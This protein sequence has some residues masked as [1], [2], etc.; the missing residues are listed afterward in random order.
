MP[1]RTGDDGRMATVVTQ[2]MLV[3][4]R[5]EGVDLTGLSAGEVARE[6]APV[7]AGASLDAVLESMRA[8]QVARL[9]VVDDGLELGIITRGDILLYRE[10]ED[11]LGSKITDLL[12]D[13]SPHD[14]MF[15]GS[16]A[17]YLASGISAVEGVRR[18]QAA[19]R[20]ETCESILDFACGHGRVLR[21]LKA[22]FPR[23]D[24]AA[25]DIDADGIAFCAQVFGARPFP[26]HTDPGQIELNGEFDLIWCGS[27]LTHLDAGL[28]S[29]YLRLFASV[30]GSGGLL[31]FTVLGPSAEPK[32]RAGTLHGAP[33]DERRVQ[34]ILET[35]DASG[36]GYSDYEGQSGYGL[37]FCTPEWV[38]R[39][40][41]AQDR[42]R[43]LHHEEGAW[44][45]QD[46]VACEAV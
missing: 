32:L 41:A 37:S 44:G 25:C 26:S 16:M 30:L 3:A 40:I 8:Q 6:V 17:G 2:R 23:A 46:I 34:A 27:L 5:N 42:L 24:L 14:Q 19:A 1:V 18:A 38:G 21:A 45:V 4:L 13:I 9:P 33:Q 20:K 22:E 28:W 11:K 35:Y 10:I 15:P 31:V 7:D 12:V 39:T 43:L 36:F 29:Q